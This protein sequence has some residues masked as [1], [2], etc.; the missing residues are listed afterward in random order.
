MN[1][2]IWTLIL[3]K[4]NYTDICRNIQYVCKSLY[5]WCRRFVLVAREKLE[6]P[7]INMRNLIEY[8][9]PR[10]RQRYNYHTETSSSLKRQI[11]HSMYYFRPRH[12]KYELNRG[13][14]IIEGSFNLE[15]LKS[16]NHCAKFFKKERD[17]R[18]EIIKDYVKYLGY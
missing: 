3:R 11:P 1:K 6:P 16:G 18:K 13:I 4:S 8:S 9:Y 15:Y 5:I 10:W 2:D 7:K 14:N 12:P 17:D